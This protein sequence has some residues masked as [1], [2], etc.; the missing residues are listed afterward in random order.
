MGGTG[1]ERTGGGPAGLSGPAARAGP[2]RPGTAGRRCGPE[3]RHGGRR[4][5]SGPGLG[6]ASC[7]VYEA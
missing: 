3:R 4:P 7:G 2:P 6:A 1:P 5:A